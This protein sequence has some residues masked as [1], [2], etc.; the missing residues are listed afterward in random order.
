MSVQHTVHCSNHDTPGAWEG[1]PVPPPGADTHGSRRP[2]GPTHTAAAACSHPPRLHRILIPTPVTAPVTLGLAHLQGSHLPL[3]HKILQTG[4]AT[5]LSLRQR[6]GHG[7]LQESKHIHDT[8]K[9]IH[10]GE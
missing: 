8:C 5:G 7:R 10:V 1:C 6:T 9:E 4:A 3:A 2:Q